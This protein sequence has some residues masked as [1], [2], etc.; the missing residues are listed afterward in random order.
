MYRSAV[1]ALQE[2]VLFLSEIEK[3]IVA[4]KFSFIGRIKFNLS[5][6]LQFNIK[7]K[8]LFHKK[9]TQT[10]PFL[11]LLTPLVEE[12]REIAGFN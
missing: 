4:L 11:I 9:T 12:T 3:Q 8:H 1:E 2:L 10:Q 5:L 7:M 6:F